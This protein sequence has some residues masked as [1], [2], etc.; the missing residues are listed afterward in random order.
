V[1]FRVNGLTLEERFGCTR[2]RRACVAK[3][4]RGATSR[5]SRQQIPISVTA[6]ALLT[7]FEVA[8]MYGQPGFGDRQP[9]P[10]PSAS[11]SEI[12]SSSQGLSFELNRARK[13]LE[14]GQIE[15]APSAALSAARSKPTPP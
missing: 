2:P 3:V 12:L 10:A 1:I 6:I 14:Q 11:P 7:V 9:M 5:C 15:K 4:A 13:L 8:G